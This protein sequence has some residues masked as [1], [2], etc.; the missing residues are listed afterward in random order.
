[1]EFVRSFHCC[2]ASLIYLNFLCKFYCFF[3]SSLHL[4]LLV[5]ACSSHLGRAWPGLPTGIGSQIKKVSLED[6]KCFCFFVFFF[7]FSMNEMKMYHIKASSSCVYN[8]PHPSENMFPIWCRHLGE[9]ADLKIIENAGHAVNV[10]KPKEMFKYMKAFLI[11]QL[12]TSKEDHHSNGGK[13][14]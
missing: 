6:V 5:A 1:M 8:Q 3:N 10:E 7:W 14:D 12:P 4:P 9:N 13:A 2:I 11:D